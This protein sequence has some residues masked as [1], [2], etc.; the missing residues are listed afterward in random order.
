MT[1]QL[2]GRLTFLLGP[3]VNDACLVTAG[4][5]RF[6]A[7]HGD[8]GDRILVFGR[9]TGRCPVSAI[10]KPH[11]LVS[12][13]GKQQQAIGAG[14]DNGDRQSVAG[15][16]SRR[17]RQQPAADRP[18]GA[19]RHDT[20]GCRQ[21]LQIQHSAVMTEQLKFAYSIGRIPQPDG[22]HLTATDDKLSGQVKRQR[23]DCIRMTRQCT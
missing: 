20:S 1:K 10:E 4:K 6:I 18:I 17:L 22:S 3:D 14:T 16:I 12:T 9:G 11:D 7:I 2:A 23:G 5:Y 21:Q 8:R 13:A 19:G 15:M